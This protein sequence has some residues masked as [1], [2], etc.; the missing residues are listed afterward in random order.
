M[1]HRTE[2]LLLRPAWPEDW[3]MILWGIGDARVVRNLARAP[4]PY[5]PEH[6][7]EFVH[8]ALDPRLPA[9]LLTLPDGQGSRLVGCAGLGPVVSE[10]DASASAEL[11][12]WIARPYW[13][14]GYATESAR[15]VLEIARIIGHHRVSAGHF[16]DNPASGRVLRKLGFRPTGQVVQRHSLAR[17]RAEPLVE[18]ALDLDGFADGQ[19]HAA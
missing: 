18:Y 15:G 3:E 11:G 14:R 19:M 9:F 12:Y 8:R 7:R 2:R 5:L 13:G 4:W 1:F 6:A 16:T 17:G 10:Q